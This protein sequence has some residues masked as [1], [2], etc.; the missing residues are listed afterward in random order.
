M[1]GQKVGVGV[2]VIIAS[3][4][5]DGNG[6]TGHLHVL[7]GKRKGSHGAGTW[8]FPGGHIDFGETAI[9]TVYRELEEETGITKDQL[10]ILHRG[11]YVETVFEED[12][13][14]YV[15]LLFY[16]IVRSVIG[17]VDVQLKEPDKCEEWR[18]FDIRKL[19]SPL[20]KPI[21]KYKEALADG[22]FFDEFYE[23]R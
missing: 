18:W 19:P 14:H 20:F 5:G 13:K 7:L 22:S 17:A 8:S 9:E 16:T 23:A 1:S 2:S 11:P 4:I 21:E 12:G 15:T 10:G 3:Y 6:G